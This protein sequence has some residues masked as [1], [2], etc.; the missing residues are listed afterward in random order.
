MTKGPI[1]TNANTD[2]FESNGHRVEAYVFGTWGGATL[3]F[4]HSPDGD[5]N[6]WLD[7][8]NGSFTANGYV[9]LDYNPGVKFRVVSTNTSGSTS[10]SVIAL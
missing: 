5:T 7:V 1:T 9:R 10:L 3:K 8:P 4:Q 6:R 2:L